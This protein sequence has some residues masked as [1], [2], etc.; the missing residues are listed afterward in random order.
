MWSDYMFSDLVQYCDVNSKSKENKV[1][2]FNLAEAI[3]QR[4]LRSVYLHTL[5]TSKWF[6]LEIENE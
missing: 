3:R 1:N 5:F 6:G 2:K 4:K